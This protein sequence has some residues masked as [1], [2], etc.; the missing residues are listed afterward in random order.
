[1]WATIDIFANKVRIAMAGVPIFGGDIDI[2]AAS[3]NITEAE[4]VIKASQK[5]ILKGQQD[6]REASSKVTIAGIVSTYAAE[7]AKLKNLID[8]MNEPSDES[9]GSDTNDGGEGDSDGD[10]TVSEEI[11]RLKLISDFKKKIIKEEKDNAAVT[12]EEKLALKRERA[13]SE[14]D[15]FV[16]TETEKR[17]ALIAVN[18]HYDNLEDELAVKTAGDKQARIQEIED[19]YFLKGL[20]REISNIE[21]KAEA[22]ILE[23]EALG[24]HKDLIEQIE[25]ES[26][27]KIAKITKKYSDNAIAN[28]KTTEDKKMTT[29]EIGIAS[30]NSLNSA[31]SALTN[32][33]G[34]KDAE[35]NE[36][37]A[38]E[39]FKVDKAMKLASGAT[40]VTT[41]IMN[42]FSQTSDP[43]PTQTL[44]MINA[45]IA[46]AVG[47]ANLA[48]IASSSFEGGGSSTPP[49]TAAAAAP[50]SFN[51][52][53]GTEGNQIQNSIDGQFNNAGPL[54]AYV[55]GSD[56]TS[57]QSL[58]RQIESDS[59]I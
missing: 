59:G 24:A 37:R 14:L 53:E 12:E 21:R 33:L 49:P 47:L 58:D 10:E 8:S 35:E 13:I 54:K 41:G 3:K 4:N 18:R 40:S 36:E 32:A 2:A 42:A 52:V 9:G 29:T 7:Q 50:P 5:R 19:F 48:T 15:S 45:G 31:A 23:L 25:Q 11:A 16:G 26:A 38:R 43:S 56:V 1:M 46:G 55:V 28:N 27:D 44:R 34:D 20:E 6:Q 39:A 17:E 51:L 30:A 22:D 57:Q